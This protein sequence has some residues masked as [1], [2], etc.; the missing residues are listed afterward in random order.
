MIPSLLTALC[1]AMAGISAR[2][3]TQCSGAERANTGRLLVGVIILGVLALLSWQDMPFR[4]MMG[5]AIAGGIGFGFGGFCMLQSLKRLGTPTSLLMVESITAVMAGALAWVTVKDT[6][7][8]QQILACG[9][10]ISSVLFAGWTWMSES[11]PD[12]LRD[13]YAGYSFAFLAS[14]FQSISL[15]ISRQ[16]FVSAAQSGVPIEKLD[17]AFVRM[18]GG[19]AIASLF[20]LSLYFRQGALP[21]F[22]KH[23]QVKF[24]WVRRGLPTLQQPLFWIMI[25]GLFGPVF[26]VTCWL[27]AVSLMNPGIVQSIAAVAPLISLPVARILE[28][29]K[30]GLQFYI[31]AP[32]A[33][34]GIAL[35]ALS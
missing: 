3:S 18:V 26:G 33:I 21:D 22:L 11:Q 5:L 6:M 23:E 32:V 35:L 13:R 16:V 29:E 24:Q 10:I 19:A 17:A 8:L 30:L 15:V 28:K 2:Q 9:I 27:W 7:N 4:S 20:M 34:I 1:F 31:G 14:T 12:A 25:N